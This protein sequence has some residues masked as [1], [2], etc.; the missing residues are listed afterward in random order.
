MTDMKAI[1]YYK[2]GDA[3][4][5]EWIDLPEPEL[6]AND[7]LVRVEAVSVNP[8][9]Y[10]VRASA[11]PED[12]KPRILGY[13]AAGTVIRAGREATLFKPGDE[14]FY[15]GAL[16]RPGTN[17]EY[18]AVDE[19]L[20]GRKP[21]SL[22]WTRAAALPLTA[23]TALELLFDRMR[24]LYAAK[25]SGGRLLI[26]NG[27]GG[28][29]SNLTQLARRLTGLTVI[30]TSSRP[31]AT[32]WCRRMGAQ[33]IIDHHKPP[34]E[35]MKRI[36][37]NQ[38]NL[39]AGLTATDRHMDAITRL[40]APHGTL[41]LIDDPKSLD[42]VPFKMKSVTV[43][44]EFMFTPS[45]FQTPNMARH[46]FILNEVS[47]LVDAGVLTSTETT[48]LDAMTPETLAEA[49]RLA[50]GGTSIGKTVLPGIRA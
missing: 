1:G 42:I 13:D 50:E 17:A 11:Q 31:E 29:G 14:V 47:A 27:A 46:G 3:G 43:A 25:T 44:W 28:V 10:K 26:I 24:V 20:V 4:V 38:A 16:A 35:E 8:V 21:E 41:A 32:E 23:L 5:L 30:A 22:S 49:H 37:I 9:D 33:H 45:M 15:A 7:L 48:T 6:G 34:N 40:I 2:P 12:E 19:R 18:H 36:G 39:V